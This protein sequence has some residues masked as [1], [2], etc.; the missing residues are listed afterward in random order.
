MNM[1]QI[2]TNTN[3]QTLEVLLSRCD[4]KYDTIFSQVKQRKKSRSSIPFID[5]YMYA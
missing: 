3:K 4:S 5:A 2:L 1:H